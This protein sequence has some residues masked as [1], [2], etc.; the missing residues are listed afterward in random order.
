M[1]D[2]IDARRPFGHAAPAGYGEFTDD[3]WKIVLR[4]ADP[5]VTFVAPE[6]AHAMARRSGEM[7]QLTALLAQPWVYAGSVNHEGMAMADA[8]ERIG[9]AVLTELRDLPADVLNQLVPIPQA[10]T[11]FA[12]ATHLL[13][14]GEFWVLAVAGGREI[15]RDREAEFH[16]SGTYADLEPRYIRWIRDARSVL[17]DLDQNAWECVASPP[18]GFT[19]SLDDEPITVRGCVLHAI[20]HSALH[21]GQ[22][23]LTKSFLT[24]P[25]R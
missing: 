7:T 1:T 21:L 16:A 2:V 24:H 5:L 13:G 15:R 25:S 8:L 6:V 11:L 9:H 17:S 12:L 4:R 3:A 23:Q 14:A 22:I 10:N 18:P 19:G 20:E